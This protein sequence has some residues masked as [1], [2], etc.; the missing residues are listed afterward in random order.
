MMFFNYADSEKENSKKFQ[1]ISLGFMVLQCRIRCVWLFLGSNVVILYL[2]NG[3][4]YK[5]TPLVKSF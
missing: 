1:D 3:E 5:P 4:V 2:F